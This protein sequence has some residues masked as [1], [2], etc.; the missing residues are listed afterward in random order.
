MAAG[1]NA[2]DHAGQNLTSKVLLCPPESCVV[3]G[4]GCAGHEYTVKRLQNCLNTA[5]EV[6]P[7]LRFDSLNQLIL[8]HRS[9]NTTSFHGSSCANNG[10]GAHY[11][12][13]PEVM[14]KARRKD[15]Y[16]SLLVGF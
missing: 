8:I 14:C 11:L 15:R 12:N 3:S 5:A 9:H 10:K 1:A 13:T 16:S 4:I 7:H 2:T 6:H